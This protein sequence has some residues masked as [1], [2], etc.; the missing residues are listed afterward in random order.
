[1]MASVGLLVSSKIAK[2]TGTKIVWL[3]ASTVKATDYGGVAYNQSFAYLASAFW[4]Y[5]SVNYV[6]AGVSSNDSAA[7]LARL[8]TDVISLNPLICVVNAGGIGDMI[9]AVSLSSYKAN[10]ASI[11]SQLQNAG[12]KIIAVNDVMKRWTNLTL[13]AQFRTYNEAYEEIAAQYNVPIIDIYREFALSYIIDGYTNW[14]NY[15]VDDVHQ[16]IAGNAWIA[17][18]LNKPKYNGLFV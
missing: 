9:N 1:M 14:N 16:T 7:M 3:G 12:I 13:F 18:I 5:T 10:L 6:N 4:G 17:N 8:S 15:Y 11:F 2:A